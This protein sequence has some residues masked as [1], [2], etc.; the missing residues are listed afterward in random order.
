MNRLTQVQT[1]P[2]ILFITL[3]FALVLF[4][5]CEE[6]QASMED[7]TAVPVTLAT[8]QTMQAGDL[9]TFAGNV[10]SDNQASLSTIVMGTVEDLPVSVGQEVRRGDVLAQIKDD[11]IRAKKMQLEANMVQ[12]KAN[13][14]NTEKNYERIKNLYAEESATSKELDDMSTMYDVAKANVEALEASLSEVNEMLE[15]TVIR[16]PFDGIVS[17]KF[18]SEGD[19]AAPGHPLLSIADPGSIKITAN[20]PE[21]WIGRISEGDT[22]SVAVSAAGIESTHAVLTAVSNAAD[23]MSRQYAI[24][25]K[26]LDENIAGSL[27]TGMFAEIMIEAEGDAAL[28][29]PVS[30]LTTRGQLT[31][32]FTVSD[33]NR[34]VLRW[35]RTGKTA[36]ESVEIL[37]GLEPGEQYI[38]A[39]DHMLQQG[40]LVTIQ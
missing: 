25:A 32:L 14:R 22:V 31:G 34:T 20:V 28:Y 5:G 4:Q 18:V 38:S 23:P 24:E 27:K 8:A 15:Y 19:M 6:K 36:G 33:N 13:L 30:A 11:Q 10:E 29:V 17:H 21:R 37:T 3:L 26:L 9:Q 7:E 1:A 12:A 40:Q 2:L 35:I 16:A 39:S